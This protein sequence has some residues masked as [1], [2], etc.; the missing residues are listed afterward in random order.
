VAGAAAQV[1][2]IRV[3]AGELAQS[4]RAAVLRPVSAEWEPVTPATR[5]LELAAGTE[6]LE[7]CEKLGELP[8]GSAVITGAGQLRAQFMVHV[9]VRSLEERVSAAG[10]RRALQNGLRRLS[11]YGLESVAMPP[12]GTGAGYLDAEEA[13]AE[14]IPLLLEHLQSGAQPTCI[15]VVVD[16]SYEQEAFERELKR[17][18]LPL[19]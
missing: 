14:M 2:L 15:D 17:Y 10:V 5:R 9:I 11:E 1:A 7:Q 8:V 12:L 3:L 13:A 6:L 16:S 4:E 18:E 19:L